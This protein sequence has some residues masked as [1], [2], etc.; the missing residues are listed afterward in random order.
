M[1][2][3]LVYR[4]V[5]ICAAVSLLFICFCIP[6]SGYELLGTHISS[7]L[8]FVPHGEFGDTTIAHF[9]EALWQWNEAAGQ[10][11]MTR[12][13]VV[14]HLYTSYPCNDGNNYIYRTNAGAGYVAQ[15]TY[16][17]DGDVITSADININMY[18]SWANSAQPGCY[19]VWTVFM[20]EA[21]HVVQGLDMKAVSQVQLC[22]PEAR[23]IEQEES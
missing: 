10:S 13:P 17:P 21:G 4:V 12:H 18:Y 6:A 8:L 14:R 9:N 5:A 23:Q 1:K 20:H 19:D 7:S 16:Y 22:I 11:L 15:T 2:R 3:K